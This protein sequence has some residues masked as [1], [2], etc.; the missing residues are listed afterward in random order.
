MLLYI[1]ETNG[2]LVKVCGDFMALFGKRKERMHNATAGRG[3][4]T[5]DARHLMGID[6]YDDIEQEKP[7]D[8]TPE[9]LE[10][11]ALEEN[12]EENVEDV[13]MD[14][15]SS[16]G[17]DDVAERDRELLSN[18]DT[19]NNDYDS[20]VS[21]FARNVR[22]KQISRFTGDT[23]DASQGWVND[24]D[25]SPQES[26]RLMRANRAAVD[27]FSRLHG[28][29]KYT[30]DRV[31]NILGRWF[32][33][34]S[35]RHVSLARHVLILSIFLVLGALIALAFTVYQNS[36]MN[37][38]LVGTKD[39]CIDYVAEVAAD[40]GNGEV[41][42]PESIDVNIGDGVSLNLAGVKTSRVGYIGSWEGRVGPLRGLG[43]IG[44]VL[45]MANYYD[46]NDGY[47]DN[48]G[49]ERIGDLYIVAIAS[50]PF[51]AKGQDTVQIGDLLSIYFD[52][53]TVIKAI[54][55]DW[56]GRYV[57]DGVSLSDPQY[58]NWEWTGTDP[59]GRADSS[60]G[61]GHSYGNDVHVLEFWGIDSAGDP[62]AGAIQKST[63]GNMKRVKSITNY[64]MSADFDQF[65]HGGIIRGAS[66]N[67]ND[68]VSAKASSAVEECKADA[69]FDNS[70]IA[71]ALVS[72]S[73]SQRKTFGD[74]YPGTNLYDEVWTATI[75]DEYYRSC[76]RG[77]A[78]AVKWCGAD[79]NFEYGGCANEH[80][81][82]EASPLWE[83]VGTY[84]FG[85]SAQD[86]AD[87]AKEHLEPGDI[88]CT[89][90]N[91][92]TFAYVGSEMAKEGYKLY[93]A[94]TDADVGEPEETA[95]FVSAS[96]GSDGS[97]ST[98]TSGPSS[99][100]APCVQ[101]VAGDGRT[102]DAFR[103]VGDY[104]DRKKGKYKNVGTSVMLNAINVDGTSCDCEVVEY[105]PV[106]VRMSKFAV[107]MAITCDGYEVVTDEDLKSFDMLTTD[108]TQVDYKLY[109]DE[110]W[111]N[112]LRG[113]ELPREGGKT[114]SDNEDLNADAG[115]LGTGAWG[116]QQATDRLAFSARGT[117]DANDCW[118]PAAL[119]YR[120]WQEGDD[121][122]SLKSLGHSA[123]GWYACC[124]PWV[125]GMLAS[126]GVMN[127]LTVASAGQASDAMD[128][129]GHLMV[130]DADPSKTFDEQCKPG[131]I[132]NWPAHS[133]MYVGHDA[134][135]EKYPNS[136]AN[137]A[138][139]G[140]NGRR[141]LGLFCW[142]GNMSSNMKILRP[143]E[144]GVK[145]DPNV[146]ASKVVN[147]GPMTELQQALIDVA[148][149]EPPIGD[150]E[151]SMCMAWV[152]NVFD[153]AGLGFGHYA[154][155][156]DAVYRFCHSS[157]R[158]DLRPGMIIGAKWH[159]A[160]ANGEAG[161][162]HIGIYIG[163]GNVIDCSQGVVATTPLEDWID[164]YNGTGSVRWGW[165]GGRN[166]AAGV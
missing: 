122:R 42:I 125:S 10:E 25:A 20:D 77:V 166:L 11:E 100:R 8:A 153:N 99:G 91:S 112:C 68:M 47:T 82:L 49:F 9:E 101:S 32:P 148:N 98:R 74:G 16:L 145:N 41:E 65:A 60:T 6:A 66:A 155:A 87:W 97:A 64:G 95:V 12:V 118:L 158:N 161:I 51:A 93:L 121:K 81:Y 144:P 130:L 2:I 151:N 149:N 22:N 43:L 29:V 72:Y 13:T 57:P 157:D 126:F 5:P 75:G 133:M 85:G 135:R 37:T 7:L 110:T 84:D 96:I 86:S 109:I 39:E 141:Y 115:D 48:A 14:Y 83:K 3:W 23:E 94:D 104:A 113:G 154:T 134:V 62:M 92:H 44:D 27:G 24:D 102:Y 18:E 152:N 107:D 159:T 106:G 139:E 146:D 143:I 117:A 70:T 137:M 111:S 160:T 59:Q 138:E 56:K 31:D 55:G 63:G 129:P 162:G 34:L 45:Q 105:E 21:S 124:S 123:H 53:G 128:K 90:A 140:Q 30:E 46:A 36:A 50:G 150:A 116:Y 15:S 165:A 132:V 35:A 71:A 61:W 89:E 120:Q 76:D 38:L 52:D 17:N 80:A 26:N 147:D 33:Q 156:G 40:I 58:W 136:D 119:K 1:V 163:G 164:N 114:R 127:D 79:D 69:H 4:Y 67:V 108:P 88:L 78:A 19:L 142:S 131:D 103:Y 54:V 73:Y 28:R